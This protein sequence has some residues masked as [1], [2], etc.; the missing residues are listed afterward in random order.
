MTNLLKDIRYAAR[1]LRKNPGF[2]AV[3]IITLALGIGANTAIFS[4]VN[5][6]LLKPLPYAA[7]ERLMGFVGNQ[8]L[9]DIKDIGE[10]SQNFEKIGVFA[11]WPMDL[12]GGEQPEKIDA[13][14]IGADLFPALGVAPA[15]GRY[16]TAEDDRP[17]GPLVAVVSHAFW[18]KYLG[19]R[20]D[21]LGQPLQLSGNTY[22]IVGVMP[23]GFAMPRGKSTLWAPFSVT[24]PEAMNAR[25][26][27][28]T[29]AVARLKPGAAIANVQAELSVI[30][31][32]LGEL[33]P[34]EARTFTVAPLQSRIVR[35]VRT[36]LLVLMGAVGCVLLIA[37]ANF[38]NLLLA[39]AASRSNEMVIRAALGASRAQLVR[40]L[41]AE[42]LLLS[43]LGGAIGVGLAYWCVRALLLMDPEGVPQ[44]QPIGV[45]ANTLI[46]SV[47]ISILT[48]L[49]FGLFP[50][51]QASSPRL[52]EALKSGG[53]SVSARSGV[54]QTLVVVEMAVAVVLLAGAGLLIRSFWE[55][56]GVHPGFEPKQVATF[57]IALPPTRY[58][59]IPKQEVFFSQFAERLKQLP[60]VQQASLVSDLPMSGNRF[61]HNA[62]V[63]GQAPVQPGSEPELLTSEV[64][65][66]YFD[67]L[68]IPLLTGRDFTNA[69]NHSAALVGVVNQEFV[70]T[71]FPDG[72][73]IGKRVRWA[74]LDPPT[75][76]TIVGVVGN[77]KHDGVDQPDEPLLYTPITQKLQPWKRFAYA[78]IR[79]QSPEPMTILNSA[80]QTVWS[81]DSQLPIADAFSMDEIVT[82]ALGDRRFMMTLLV[83]FAALAF[84]LAMVGI[85]GVISY[86]VTQRT[87]E[88]GIRMALGAK[89]ADILR[90]IL[91]QGLMLAGLGLVIGITGAF[92]AT[93]VLRTLLYGIAPTDPATYI[94]SALLLVA[95]ALLASYIPA[96]RAAKVDPMVALRYE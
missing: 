56:N 38:S 15:M 59:E 1:L 93:R 92:A 69:D 23:P 22:S 64:A 12:I 37:C 40:Q 42:S 88:V 82:K 32:R 80:K 70:R 17:G 20:R 63:E 47:A 53:R 7:P 13:A 8:S 11:D 49:V 30:G 57:R 68:K 76:I 35:N 91:N 67:T 18:Q 96:R 34:E 31:K 27:H 48:G 36:S 66:G 6:V 83:A 25:G 90:L 51:F 3:A 44:L 78:V 26:A 72:Q 73:A 28:F 62:I 84:T 33:H 50:A 24:Y 10:Q 29:Y 52:T 95:V 39:K 77:V 74:R 41:L 45:D 94:S 43:L 19:G 14:I 65:P 71:Y 60:G 87:H 79:T 46:F 61:P 21:V 81:L 75:W 86:L 16:L 58:A 85:Y 5:A 55:L 4:V 2:A 9:P 54:R 89:P